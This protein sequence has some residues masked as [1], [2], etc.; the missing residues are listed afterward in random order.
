MKNKITFNI[1]KY[2]AETKKTS[3]YQDVEEIFAQN[4]LFKIDNF[5]IEKV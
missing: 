5:S 1:K 4:I 2:N 3:F